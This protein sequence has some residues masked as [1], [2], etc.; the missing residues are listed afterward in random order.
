MSVNF[1]VYGHHRGEA[2]RSDAGH[3]LDRESA[4][5]IRVALPGVAKTSAQFATNLVG[6]SNVTRRAF[7]HPDQVFP[8]WGSPELPIERR[9]SG[10]LGWG[11]GGRLADSAERRIGQ[12]AVA[13]LNGLKNGDERLWPPAFGFESVVDRSQIELSRR[14]RNRLS[15]RQRPV[16][17]PGWQ[18]L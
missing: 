1:I 7:A 10:N 2:A 14:S 15:R 13:G 8:G 11:N 18:D 6:T 16:G 4:A 5:R 12:I 9:D 3:T 17:T